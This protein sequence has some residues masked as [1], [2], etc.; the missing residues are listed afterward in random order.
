[1]TRILEG[2]VCQIEDIV[3]FRKDEGEH[4]K[5]LL[6]VLKRLESANVTL[7]PSKYEFSKTT[8]KFLG[9]YQS[10]WSQSRSRQ[11]QGHHRNGSS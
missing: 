11:D 6:K 4:R 2:V 8:V 10:Q 9:H 5:R 3:V 7:N 1:M